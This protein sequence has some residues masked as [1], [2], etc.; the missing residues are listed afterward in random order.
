MWSS[1]AMSGSGRTIVEPGGNLNLDNSGLLVLNG[2]TLENAGT[3]LWTDVGSISMNFGAVIT[4]RAGR[5]RRMSAC[6][7]APR[8]ALLS[9]A[10][11][12]V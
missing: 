9:G 1:G 11:M 8:L 6:N 4:N 5:R 7:F 3:A 10:S 12:R 2:R